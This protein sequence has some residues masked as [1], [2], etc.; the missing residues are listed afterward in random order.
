MPITIQHAGKEDCAEAASIVLRESWQP[1]AIHYTPGYMRWQLSFPAPAPSPAV[2]AWDG[3]TPA[4][5]CAVT[6]RR[7]R[8]GAQCW[9]SGIASFV[10]VRPAWRGQGLAAALYR[11]FCGAIRK[12]GA[13]IVTFGAEGSAGLKL[14][15]QAYQSAGFQTLFLGTYPF[16][17]CLARADVPEEGDWTAAQIDSADAFREGIEVFGEAATEGLPV[18]L[19]HPSETQFQ[20]YFKDPR[21]RALVILRNRS[22]GARGTAWLV[23]T[24]FTTATGVD[25][26]AS[27]ESV[28]VPGYDAAAL[29]VLFRAA[30]AWAGTGGRTLVNAPNLA[31]FAPDSLRKYGIRQTGKGFA[32]YCCGVD[33]PS[34]LQGVRSTTSEIV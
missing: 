2:I 5:F 27:L 11:E 22:T 13:P 29:P 18:I 32:G 30:A 12:M 10:A 20:H 34:F 17:V 24:E 16:Y 6:P 31:G 26:V 21:R 15:L 25:H 1:P 23:Q 9:E 7:F 3:E 8:L 28:N 14:L 19:S 33:I 4:A